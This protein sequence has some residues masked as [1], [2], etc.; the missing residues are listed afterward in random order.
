MVGITAQKPGTWLT[1]WLLLVLEG[2]GR[3][4]WYRRYKGMGG[5]VDMNRIKS[6]WFDANRLC[7][8]SLDSGCGC[9]IYWDLWQSIRNYG[10]TQEYRISLQLD[11]G[12]NRWI[13]TKKRLIFANRINCDLRREGRRSASFPFASDR[14]TFH[15]GWFLVLYPFPTL[16]AKCVPPVVA[17]FRYGHIV[18]FR[19]T[20]ILF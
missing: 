7:S 14:A 18:A 11:T 5:A 3:D 13:K 19:R 15:W 16:D 10:D 2:E 6:T 8:L 12:R 1:L 17:A 9:E 4:G 20:Y